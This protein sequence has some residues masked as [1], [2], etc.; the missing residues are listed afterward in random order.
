MTKRY[1]NKTQRSLFDMDWDGSDDEYE[2]SGPNK[3]RRNK[4]DGILGG[5]CAGLGDWLGIDHGPMRILVVLA[6]IF[7]G[8]PVII[9][10]LMWMFIPSDKRAP[11]VRE[12]R[13]HR[14]AK[15]KAKRH[16]QIDVE[17]GDTTKYSDVRSKFRSLEERLQD[18]ERSVTSREWKLR[19]DFRDLES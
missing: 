12:D 9:Y 14:R 5:V 16:G 19:R 1:R 15:R 17:L 2:Y 10:F 4:I 3:L 8:F 11:Y 6:I 7:A 18:L 13:E